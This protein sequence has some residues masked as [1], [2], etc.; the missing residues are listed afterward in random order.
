MIAL[1]D[2]VGFCYYAQIHNAYPKEYAKMI[3]EIEKDL[4]DSSS[5]SSSSSSS[6]SDSWNGLNKVWQKYLLV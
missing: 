5:D 3:K 1:L 6:S 2:A 4:N